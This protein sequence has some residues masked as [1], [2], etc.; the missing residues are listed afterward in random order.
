MPHLPGMATHSDRLAARRSAPATERNRAPILAVLRRVLPETGLILEI[1]AGTGEHAAYFSRHLPRLHW[2]PT[3]VDPGLRDSIASW[4]SDGGPGLRPPLDLEV[5][6][7]PWPVERADAVV[8][9]NMIHIAPWACTESLLAGTAEVLAPGGVLYL[10]GP[11]KVDGRHTA[12]SNES[13]ERWLRDRDPAFG[14]RDIG[15]VRELAAR[16]GLLWEESVAMPANNFS[17]VF[18]LR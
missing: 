4:A 8:C 1:A 10:Y 6:R 9:I 3:E 16:H 15:A 12:P 14:V 13:F 11:F 18:R 2:Q 7:R 5:T 17:Q